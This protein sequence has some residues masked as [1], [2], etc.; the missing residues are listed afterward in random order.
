M[1]QNMTKNMQ[2]H[3]D[4][5][6]KSLLCRIFDIYNMQNMP[7]NMQ[8]NMQNMQKNMSKLC[9]PVS[10]MQNLN[11][12]KSIFRSVGDIYPNAAAFPT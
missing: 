11:S 1:T 8:N 7:K 10:N 6:D 9:K 12:D 4:D 3:H 2:N 5:S